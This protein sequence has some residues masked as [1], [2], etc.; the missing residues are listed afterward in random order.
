M[1]QPVDHDNDETFGSGAVKDDGWEEKHKELSKTIE[2]DSS[3]LMYDDNITFDDP[4]FTEKISFD[5]EV[6]TMHGLTSP[7]INKCLC[8]MIYRVSCAPI[9]AAAI[10]VWSI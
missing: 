1:F 6:C 5:E 4:A 3:R 7:E 8:F 2:L 10:D 9:I